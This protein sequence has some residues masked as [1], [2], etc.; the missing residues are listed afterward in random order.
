[1]GLLYEIKSL[2]RQLEKDSDDLSQSEKSEIRAQIKRLKKKH[3]K[4]E[5]EAKIQEECHQVI[6]NPKRVA[7]SKLNSFSEH[8]CTQIENNGNIL[9]DAFIG[10]TGLTAR[11][12]LLKIKTFNDEIFV[13]SDQEFIST[14]RLSWKS[15]L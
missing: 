13:P 14:I 1:M 2:E 9:N 10:E 6:Q 12:E 15:I 4:K 3:Q 11:N 7:T 5:L 8:L